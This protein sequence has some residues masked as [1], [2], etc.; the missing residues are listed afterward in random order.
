MFP[1]IVLNSRKIM[2]FGVLLG[3]PT[4]SPNLYD[5]RDIAYLT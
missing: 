5:A 4:S 1:W 3:S 2:D